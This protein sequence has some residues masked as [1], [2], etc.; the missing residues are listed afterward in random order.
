MTCSVPMPPSVNCLFANV[1]KRGRVPTKRYTQ[2]RIAAG[3]MLNTQRLH[4]IAG[5]VSLEYIFG[6]DT[7]ADLGNL[8]KAATDLLVSSNLIDGD[9]KG[10]VRQITMTWGEHEGV[11]ITVRA[12]R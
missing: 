12:H 1:P 6:K 7:R 9:S 11:L 8:E 5:P 3:M 4:R 2:W 10:I